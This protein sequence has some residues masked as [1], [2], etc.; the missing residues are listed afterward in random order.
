M[1]TIEEQN[2]YDLDWFMVDKHGNIGHFASGG[3]RLPESICNI[4]NLD[5]LMSLTAFFD[6]LPTISERY[7]IGSW[8]LKEKITDLTLFEEKYKSYISYAKKGLFSYDT[9]EPMNLSASSYHLITLP[10]KRINISNI[11]E[12]V[13]RQLCF[14]DVE[15]EKSNTINLRLLGLIEN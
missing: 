14:C 4:N 5:S 6:S 3:C 10:I 11:P 9:A 12:E 2:S 8:L 13:K 15:F 7:E 1:I